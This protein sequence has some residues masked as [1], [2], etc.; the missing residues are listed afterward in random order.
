MTSGITLTDFTRTHEQGDTSLCWL[1]S[2]V[3]SLKQS[4]KIKVDSLPAGPMKKRALKFLAKGNLHQ[5][6]RHEILFGLIPKTRTGMAFN[7]ILINK[8]ITSKAHFQQLETLKSIHLD[9]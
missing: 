7:L 4:L 2:F 8:D 1:Y 6:L 3:T 5:S 9:I